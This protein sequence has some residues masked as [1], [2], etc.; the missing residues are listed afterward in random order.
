MHRGIQI[1]MSLI[2][3]KECAR[4]LGLPSKN[5]LEQTRRRGNEAHCPPYI[6][7]GKTTIRYDW[8]AVEK[9]LAER[10]NAPVRRAGGAQ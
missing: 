2:D 9:W 3:T 7:L 8:A 4:R 10:A 5:A 1:A 6:R